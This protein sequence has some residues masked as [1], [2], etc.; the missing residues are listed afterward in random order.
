MGA[1]PG[2]AQDY[3]A[4]EAPADKHVAW[5]PTD[6]QNHD[7]P[8]LNSQSISCSGALAKWSRRCL[9]Y[10]EC[11]DFQPHVDFLQVI[12]S[13]V[14][15]LE[16]YVNKIITEVLR[17]LNAD[18]CSVFF[19]DRIQSQLWCVGALDLAP[20]CMP[21]G[22]GVVG[23]IASTGSLVNLPDIHSHPSF[24][25]TIEKSTGY[26]VRA[27]LGLPIRHAMNHGDVIGVVQV[28]NKKDVNAPWF[29]ERDQVE[30]QKIAMVISDSFARHRW[31][32]LEKARAFHDSQVNSMEEMVRAADGT[33]HSMY[34]RTARC[35]T[36]TSA[37][38]AFR[39]PTSSD[40]CL[41]DTPGLD[42]VSTLNFSALDYTPEELKVLVNLMMH[43]SGCVERCK[44]PEGCLHM[45]TEG[46]RRHY[47]DNQFHNWYHGFTCMQLCYY[48]IRVT[49][50]GDCLRT[51]D[52]FALF[53]AAL[54]HD[55]D[56]PGV[57]NAFLVETDNEL[58]LRY[59]DISVL[60]NHHAALACN[61]LRG[62]ATNVGIGL[63]ESARKELRRTVIASILATDMAHHTAMCEKLQSYNSLAQF[64]LESPESRQ[65]LLSAA[66]H[67]ADLG[68]QVLPW[69]TAKIWE[70]RISQEFAAQASLEREAGRSPPPHMQFAL[71]D[72]GLRSK[73]QRDFID[74]AL[75]PLWDP[76]SHLLPELRAC[77]NNLLR[78]REMYDQ[79]RT[80]R[81][82]LQ[83]KERLMA[84]QIERAATL[85]AEMA[86]LGS[87]L[88]S[89]SS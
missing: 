62:D 18:R 11:R 59:N 38:D 87:D 77:Y 29:T 4:P 42:K 45:W 33:R 5:G 9:G 60:E 32:A 66:V 51:L 53:I 65:F 79:R 63:K 86:A 34:R 48:Q 89:E 24:D 30:L 21:I 85:D 55:M 68:H 73:L 75:I 57:S 50:M 56:H 54:C 31:T 15:T 76:Y 82:N 22:K 36:L 13:P 83:S 37:K 61:L 78:N 72:I 70:D 19:V 47:R 23:T 67:A 16:E 74:F 40:I 27:V 46:A 41:S 7:I 1:K 8:I 49:N 2:R 28:L 44:V 71:E 14:T 12:A 64:N 52:V 80:S 10:Q 20:F 26:I 43:D 6:I 3:R 88:V 39:W 58:A 17:T 81:I 69:E 84:M 25:D 35:S